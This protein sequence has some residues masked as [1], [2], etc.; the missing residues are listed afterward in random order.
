MLLFKQIFLFLGHKQLRPVKC[1]LCEKTYAKTDSLK[2][3]MESAHAN[4]QFRCS[5][6]NKTLANSQSLK[7]H[8][9]NQRC[10]FNKSEKR[11]RGSA[12]V[13][14]CF[15]ENC[16]AKFQAKTKLRDHMK[17]KHDIEVN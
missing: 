16:A 8:Q 13:F 6:C 15:A 7:L 4:T 5:N 3:H 17:E 14:I 1:T 10:R 9:D 2:L 12:R 11:N